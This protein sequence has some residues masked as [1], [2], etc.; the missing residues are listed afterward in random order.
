MADILSPADATVYG[1]LLATGHLKAAAPRLSGL[2][3]RPKLRA[4]PPKLST[5]APLLSSGLHPLPGW[6]GQ[7]SAHPAPPISSGLHPLP[8][9]A[10]R[11]SAHPATPM[12]QPSLLSHPAPPVRPSTSL[13]PPPVIRR[14]PSPL[15][16][17]ATG[18]LNAT[19]LTTPGHGMS[20][21]DYNK[22]MRARM[23][24][25]T[26]VY[27][28]QAQLQP[29]QALQGGAAVRQPAPADARRIDKDIRTQPE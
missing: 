7:Q 23:N 21:E 12:A 24:R 1:Y 15:P 27:D 18:T 8:S 17:P 2:M 9:W 13:L 25:P 10:G 20:P 6:A 26:D 14:M 5:P 4:M 3:F 19:V 29:S 11:Q 22:Y 28:A 16:Q